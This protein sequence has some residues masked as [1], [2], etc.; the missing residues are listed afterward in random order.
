MK[1]E[2]V[3]ELYNSYVEDLRYISE[4]QI[5]K[6]NLF[7]NHYNNDILDA[8]D[9]KEKICNIFITN[10]V[11]EDKKIEYEN[12]WFFTQ[13]YA[14]ELH[15]FELE[16]Y[17]DIAYFK[18]KIHF[19]EIKKENYFP[20]NNIR[21]TNK[22]SRLFVEAHLANGLNLTLKASDV[23]CYY[24]YRILKEILLPNVIIQ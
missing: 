8:V 5:N 14:C 11:N 18:N 23:N 15:K 19:M 9:K 21:E 3:K 2:N 24:L 4:G 7:Y 12:L 10:I 22:E 13:N 20:E 17:Y 16:D 6:I 1:K